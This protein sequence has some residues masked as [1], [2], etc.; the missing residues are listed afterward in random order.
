MQIPVRCECGTVTGFLEARGVSVHGRCYCLDCQAFARYLGKPERM[1]DAEGGTE[2]IGT[3][4]LRLHFT[5]GA[6]RLAC[7]TLSARGPLRWY[8]ECCRMAICNSS[9]A[10]RTP[11]VTLNTRT[12]AVAPREVDRAF[13]R[14]GFIFS[15]KAAAAP[16]ASK[17]L[18][19]FFALP[20][21][22]W[23]VIYARLTGA[24]RKNPLFK[25][26]TDEP[27]RAPQ[28][29]SKEQRYALRGDAAP[30]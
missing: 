21:I 9:R 4:P 18:G 15:A 10:P 27:I 1:L 11:F 19:L 23:N 2:V 5:A 13:G 30:N 26:G 12:L 16:V 14:S 24:W 20:K 29:L 25:P 22:L 28:Q 8:A 17:P 3:L 6:D 7:I